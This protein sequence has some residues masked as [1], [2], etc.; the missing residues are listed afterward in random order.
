M[1]FDMWRVVWKV[2]TAFKN[3]DTVCFTQWKVQFEGRKTT[4]ARLAWHKNVFLT[5]EVKRLLLYLRHHHSLMISFQLTVKQ[6]DVDGAV[7]FP[8]GFGLEQAGAAHW[9]HADVSK[10]A[11]NAVCCCC[12]STMGVSHWGRRLQGYSYTDKAELAVS[13]HYQI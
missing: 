9:S 7:P 13:A 8:C 5:S 10:W 11:L 3:R 6:Q 4:Q 12:C 2:I 1:Y